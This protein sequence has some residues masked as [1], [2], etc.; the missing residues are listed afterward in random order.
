MAM[1]R[2][3]LMPVGGAETAMWLTMTFVDRNKPFTED[4]GGRPGAEASYEMMESLRNFINTV[5]VKA[6]ISMGTPR[7]KELSMTGWRRF[8]RSTRTRFQIWRSL[9][10]AHSVKKAMMQDHWQEASI[11]EPEWTVLMDWT[12]S[13]KTLA[14][15]TV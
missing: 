14:T 10:A 3:V 11:N 4:Q 5:N 13:K 9:T 12:P 2:A 1:C 8:T 7:K 15:W 6:F